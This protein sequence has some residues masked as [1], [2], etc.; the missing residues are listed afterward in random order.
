MIHSNTN[1]HAK[2]SSHNIHS[3][4]H[5]KQASVNYPDCQPGNWNYGHNPDRVTRGS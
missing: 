1:Y 2:E 4:Y 3:I 5:Q